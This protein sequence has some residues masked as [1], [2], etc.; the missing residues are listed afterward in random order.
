VNCH[1]VAPSLVDQMLFANGKWVYPLIPRAWGTIGNATCSHRQEKRS[2]TGQMEKRQ[3]HYWWWWCSWCV[4]LWPSVPDGALP[5]QHPGSP[6][7][8]QQVWR[9]TTRR[10]RLLVSLL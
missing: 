8:P 1:V 2:S 4:W 6:G 7:C 10:Q 3:K 5:C 9:N